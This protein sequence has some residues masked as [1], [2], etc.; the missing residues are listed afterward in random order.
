M[1]NVKTRSKDDRKVYL[2]TPKMIL[3]SDCIWS[4]YSNSEFQFL[5]FFKDLKNAF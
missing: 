3:D 4:I 2:G 1:Q 5:T